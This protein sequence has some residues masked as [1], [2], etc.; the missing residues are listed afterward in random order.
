[1]LLVDT[2]LPTAN[3]CLRAFVFDVTLRAQ[4]YIG[5]RFN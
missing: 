2:L 5:R 1:M 3:E 4:R